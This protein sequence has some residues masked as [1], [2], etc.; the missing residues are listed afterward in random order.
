MISPRRNRDRLKH[1][2][3]ELGVCI[4]SSTWPLNELIVDEARLHQGLNDF[5]VEAVEV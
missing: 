2:L 5:S 4:A 1:T 3:N